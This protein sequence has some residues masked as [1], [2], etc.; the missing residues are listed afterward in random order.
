MS[1]AFATSRV[2]LRDRP[3]VDVLDLSFRFLRDAFG[4]LAKLS[5]IVLPL[6][7]AATVALGYAA[8]WAW[9]WCFAL[10]A[11][12]FVAA[13]FTVLVGQ[14]VFERDPSVRVAVRGGIRA[15]PR[16]FV[17]SMV[18]GI[19]VGA[20][21]MF[22]VFPAFWIASIT[23]FV[24][25]ALLLERSTMLGAFERSFRLAARAPGEATLVRIAGALLLFFA[26]I[27]TDQ[28]GHIVLAN[29]FQVS[30]PAALFDAGGSWLPVLGFWLAVPY[31]AVLR[32]LVYINVRTRTEGWDIQTAFATLTSR[33]EDDGV[34]SR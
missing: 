13:P 23:A 7:F 31:A 16:L 3:F 2:A 4:P 33:A 32:F 25:E 26:P 14:F 27:V 15:I 17:V 28:I 21:L 19:A 18:L 34:P 11:S 24:L 29:V 5:L 9:A 8:G 1:I 22:F 6:P 12:F 20:G 10:L 30:G